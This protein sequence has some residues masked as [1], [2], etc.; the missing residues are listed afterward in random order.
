MCFRC[1]Y[2]LLG[3]VSRKFW[4]VALFRVVWRAFSSS[5]PTLPVLGIPS[6]GVYYYF[7]ILVLVVFILVLIIFIYLFF[8]LFLGL[9]LSFFF[10]LFI[11]TGPLG[12]CVTGAIGVGA[13]GSWLGCGLYWSLGA[14]LP[15][16]V[17][18]VAAPGSLGIQ[19]PFAAWV[20][21]LVLPQF[22]IG[23]VV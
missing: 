12:F 21:I 19:P 6:L 13:G 18:A 17:F 14:L 5:P 11:S 3:I 22:E 15:W 20:L 7:S 4:G 1:A 23:W 16:C 10:G 9:L 8:S 2:V